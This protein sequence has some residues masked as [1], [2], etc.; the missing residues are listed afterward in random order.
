MG[1]GPRTVA[2]V[3]RPAGVRDPLPGVLA[4]HDHGGFKF[5]GKE[6]IADGPEMPGPSVVELRRT[7]LR[8][9]RFCQ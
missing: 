3:L 7:T 1:Y 4:L 5:Y 9:P 8:R 6:K 2:W